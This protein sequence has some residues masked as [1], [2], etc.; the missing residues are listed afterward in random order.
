MSRDDTLPCLSKDGSVHVTDERFNTASHLAALVFSLVGASYLIVQ[1]SLTASV[2][3]VV[4][5]SLYGVGLCSLFLC[6]TLH[7]GVNASPRTERFLQTLDY[8]AI[9][10]LIAGTFSPVCLIV[11][12]DALGWS[13]LGSVW[14]VALTGMTLKASVPSFPK[15]LGLCL[16]VILGWVASLMGWALW[17]SLGF[18]AMGLL[19]LGG[20]FY[21]AG[22]VMFLIE[23]PNPAP[24]FFGFHEIWHLFVIAGAASHYGLMLLLLNNPA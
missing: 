22:G 16:Y 6:S 15:W 19:A 13:V 5:Y 11:G 24:G 21:T 8:L 23:K 18:E 12:R 20:V 17:Q 7:H 10:L 14:F 2:W 1:A 4:G 9:Y 3:H